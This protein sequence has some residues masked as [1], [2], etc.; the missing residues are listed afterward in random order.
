[1]KIAISWNFE[2]NLSSSKESQ[3]YKESK[4]SAE[5]YVLLN[6]HLQRDTGL[7]QSH[8]ESRHYSEFL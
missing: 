7:S 6:T 4:R 8:N 1:M 2:L 3:A 5:E